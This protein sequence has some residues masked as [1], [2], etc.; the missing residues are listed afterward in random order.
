MH[1][2][3]ALAALARQAARV[4][5]TARIKSENAARKYIHTYIHTYIHVCC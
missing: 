1:S 3:G 2:V 4:A 5:E